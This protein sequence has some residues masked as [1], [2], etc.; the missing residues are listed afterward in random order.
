ML[1]EELERHSWFLW[2]VCT[3]CAMVCPI[4]WGASGSWCYEQVLLVGLE[5][6]V[7]V[8][9]AGMPRKTCLHC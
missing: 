3:V 5:C 2:V 9:E 8:E 1:W 7:R 6:G 4:G